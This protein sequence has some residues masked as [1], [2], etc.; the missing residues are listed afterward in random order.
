MSNIQPAVHVWIRFCFCFFYYRIV[1]IALLMQSVITTS[2]SPMLYSNSGPET[3]P[4]CLRTNA[5]THI[6]TYL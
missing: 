1:G 2:V 5:S 6:T 3:D 4:D